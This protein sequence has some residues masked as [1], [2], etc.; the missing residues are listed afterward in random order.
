MLLHDTLVELS[1]ENFREN[2]TW[3]L[4]V[5]ETGFISLPNLYFNEAG[6]YTIRLLQPQDKRDISLLSPSNAFQTTTNTCFGA[7][8]M[9]NRNDMIR[10][11]ISTAACDTSAMKKR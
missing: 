10:Q 7:F 3:K 1:Y 2:L 5:P 9:A 8:S 11:K 4:F 6:I